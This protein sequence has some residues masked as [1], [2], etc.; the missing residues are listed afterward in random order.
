MVAKRNQEGSGVW[1]A[2]GFVISFLECLIRMTGTSKARQNV[3][4][5]ESKRK[6]KNT[7]SEG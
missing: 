4:G 1:E 6:G 3:V 2:P 7:S 5:M